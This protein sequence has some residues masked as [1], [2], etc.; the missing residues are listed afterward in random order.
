MM[1]TEHGRMEM[2]EMEKES[3][4]QKGLFLTKDFCATATPVAKGNANGIRQLIELV[5]L[6]SISP[7][8]TSC[9]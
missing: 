1:V 7:V 5:R 2:V 3:E 6:I 9:R 8:T 4:Q